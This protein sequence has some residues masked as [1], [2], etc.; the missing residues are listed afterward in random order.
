MG[1]NL[2]HTRSSSCFMQRLKLC[3]YIYVEGAEAP[4]S[5][6]N[7]YSEM[8]LNG[9]VLDE[10]LSKYEDKEREICKW[11]YRKIKFHCLKKNTKEHT[12]HCLHS[13]LFAD[14]FRLIIY[15]FVIGQLS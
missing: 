15:P 4:E 2:P 10:L 13:K 14:V 3:L 9:I 6:E 8:S 11:G 1:L 7:R 12:R 5:A